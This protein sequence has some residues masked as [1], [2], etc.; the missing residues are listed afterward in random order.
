[1]FLVE[2]AESTQFRAS[3]SAAA[4]ILYLALHCTVTIR[5]IDLAMAGCEDIDP[6]V[7]FHA[8][9]CLFGRY[10]VIAFVTMVLFYNIVFSQMNNA[11]YEMRKQLLR[12]TEWIDATLF[13]SIRRI[14]KIR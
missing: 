4:R 11:F 3:C 7:L 14:R 12:L 5:L 1:V 13:H 6:I 8:V 9:N 10:N 2:S